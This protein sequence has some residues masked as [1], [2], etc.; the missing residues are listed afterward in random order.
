MPE[1]KK[2][3]LLDELIDDFFDVSWGDLAHHVIRDMIKPMV[4]NGIYDILTDAIRY[5]LWGGK[6]GP[7]TSNRIGG[8]G[9][10]GSF[11]SRDRRT[12]PPW[13]TDD[14]KIYEAI[15]DT[16]EAAK[17]ALHQFLGGI[18]E[19]G[20]IS[21]NEWCSICKKPQEYTYQ[22]YGWESYMSNRSNGLDPDKE[23]EKCSITMYHDKW[24]LTVPKPVILDANET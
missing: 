22:N 3:S 24:K 13:K 7:S 6:G 4:K 1:D 20:W 17:D 18:K 15:F 2:P 14:L 9:R 12:S 10:D 8:G 5:K 11:V 16:R 21:V 23:F 19:N